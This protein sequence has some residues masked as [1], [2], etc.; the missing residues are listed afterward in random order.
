MRGVGIVQLIRGRAEVDRAYD[1]PQI[2]AVD[3]DEV[4]CRAVFSDRKS[5]ISWRSN[6]LL[7]PLQVKNGTSFPDLQRQ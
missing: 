1:L 6:P 3:G 2:V 5:G 7:I 4:G